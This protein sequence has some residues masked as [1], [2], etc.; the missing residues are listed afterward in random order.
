[1]ESAVIPTYEKTP[2][3]KQLDQNFNQNL[4]VNL[5]I[6]I[7]NGWS[8]RTAISKAKINRQNA[9]LS[10][11]IAKNQLRQTIEQAY[12]DAKAALKTYHAKMKTV[13]A[14]QK[15]YDYAEKKYKVGLMN[16]TDFDAAKTRLVS[17]QSDAIRAK[18]D[19]VFKTKVLDFYQGKP[20]TLK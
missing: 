2:F 12:A 4:S 1:L 5:N 20:L 17:A 10:L 19:F 14:S 9:E 16:T 8:S 7:F 6:P 15:S 13:E 3:S 18:Y 11:E